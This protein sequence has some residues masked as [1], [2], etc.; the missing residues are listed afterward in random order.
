MGGGALP[1]LFPALVTLLQLILKEFELYQIHPDLRIEASDTKPAGTD[2][3]FPLTRAL[4]V[5]LC[6]LIKIMQKL[7]PDHSLRIVDSLL[8]S[9]VGN[10]SSVLDLFKILKK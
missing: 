8:A 5:M 10:P 1:T 2:S 3:G 4:E 7:K 9:L 6:E